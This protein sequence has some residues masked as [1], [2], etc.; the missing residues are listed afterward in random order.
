MYYIVYKTYPQK[1]LG[2]YEKPIHDPT[3]SIQVWYLLSTYPFCNKDP[4]AN[5]SMLQLKESNLVDISPWSN[6]SDLVC[7]PN[8]LSDPTLNSMNVPNGITFLM[9]ISKPR[10]IIT[11]SVHGH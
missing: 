1:N 7:I 11:K 6:R 8:R 3:M 5:N 2:K 9:Y 10:V 4:G